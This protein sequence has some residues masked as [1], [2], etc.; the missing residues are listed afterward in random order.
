MGTA[1]CAVR[2][3][4]TLRIVTATMTDLRVPSERRY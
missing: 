1:H 4:A 3:S 2:N